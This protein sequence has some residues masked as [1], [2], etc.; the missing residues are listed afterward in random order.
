MFSKKTY[1]AYICNYDKYEGYYK[2]QFED[3]DSEEYYQKEIDTMLHNLDKNNL[4]QALSATQFEHVQAQYANT[5]SAYNK[6]S[7]FT[8]GYAK[9][10]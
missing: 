6:P 10:I 7:Q 5:Q 2:V 4:L 8:G 9:A 1:R 3:G